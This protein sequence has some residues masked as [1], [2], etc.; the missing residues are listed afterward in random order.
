MPLIHTLSVLLAAPH[1][2]HCVQTALC[3]LAF[4]Y[5]G[6]H[7]MFVFLWLLSLNITSS[8]QFILLQMTGSHFIYLFSLSNGILL[9]MCATFCLSIHLL[10]DT[11]TK[12]GASTSQDPAGLLHSRAGLIL[13]FVCFFPQRN[14]L[15]VFH[16]S[17]TNLHFHE[18]CII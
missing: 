3:C 11:Y 1:C 15:I 13:V 16:S 5:E 18:L 4:A 9:D 6:A 10:V 12:V 2:H 14:L 17:H 7:A 8:V